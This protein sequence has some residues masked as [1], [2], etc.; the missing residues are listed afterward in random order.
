MTIE[1]R[2]IEGLSACVKFHIL[3]V[4]PRLNYFIGNVGDSIYHL[5]ACEL[6]L[7]RCNVLKKM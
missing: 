2:Y 7:W 6:M 5:D 1:L 4:N 3:E